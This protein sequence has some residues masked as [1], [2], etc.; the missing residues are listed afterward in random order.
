[1]KRWLILSLWLVVLLFAAHKIGAQQSLLGV[2]GAGHTTA[3]A[4]SASASGTPLSGAA[5]LTVNFTGAGANGTPPYTFGWTFGDGGTSAAQSPS[6]SYVTANTF[7]ATLTVTDSV[8]AT[9]QATVTITTS[10]T[11]AA[12]DL[13]ALIASS[14]TNASIQLACGTYRF[15]TDNTNNCGSNPGNYCQ[16]TPKL[17][18]KFIGQN[19][20]LSYPSGPL[21][22]VPTTK[23]CVKLNGAIVVPTNSTSDHSWHTFGSPTVWYNT[24]GSANVIN[25]VAIS[26]CADGSTACQYPQDLYLNDVMVPRLST[27]PVGGTGKCQW[28]M[29]FT[30]AVGA[31][32]ANTIYV[33]CDPTTSTAE[34]SV[35]EQ[36]FNL[37]AGSNTVENVTI[38]KFASPL[39]T[40]TVR[41]VSSGNLVNANWI[42][43]NHGEG[44][45]IDTGAAMPT[46][47]YNEI[48]ENG[49]VGI[50]GVT[51]AQELDSF[52]KIERNNE[53]GIA[54]TVESGGVYLSADARAS[55]VSNTIQN[56]NGHGLWVT[57]QSS[58]LLAQNNTISGNI[59]EG[60]RYEVSGSNAALASLSSVITNTIS[61]NGMN[62][63]AVCVASHVPTLLGGSDVC[64]GAGTGPSGTAC[65]QGAYLIGGEIE[66]IDGVALTVGG[67]KTTSGNTINSHCAGMRQTQDSR[68]AATNVYFANNTFNALSHSLLSPIGFSS[69]AAFNM[70]LNGNGFDFNTY[71]FLQDADWQG[72]STPFVAEGV[73]G[74]DQFINTTQ[75]ASWWGWRYRHNDISGSVTP[76][77]ACPTTV[78]NQK[79]FYVS[80][81]GSNANPG[82]SPSS[83]WATLAFTSTQFFNM[84][85]GTRVLL[86]SGNLWGEQFNIGQGVNQS[87]VGTFNNPIIISTYG[88]TARAKIDAQNTRSFCVNAESPNSHGQNVN[89]VI[90]DNIECTRA[91]SKG[92]T[93]ISDNVSQMHGIVFSNLLLYDNGPGCSN[94]NNA[95]CVGNDASGGYKNQLNF[96]NGNTGSAKNVEM[97]FDIVK[98]SGGHNCLEIHLDAGSALAYG[99]TIGPG[100]SHNF[101]DVKTPGDADINPPTFATYI[102]NVAT[103][104]KSTS[105]SFPGT[106]FYS[107]NATNGSPTGNV[108]WQNNL[109]YDSATSYGFTPSGCGGAACSAC[110]GCPCGTACPL[111]EYFY[112]NTGYAGSGAAQVF[113]VEEGVNRTLTNTQMTFINNIFDGATTSI[114]GSTDMAS[115]ACV[116]NHNNLGGVQHSTNALVNF[117]NI[118]TPST[119]DQRNVPPLYV[120]AAGLDFHLQAKSPDLNVG[121]FGQTL[122]NPNIGAFGTP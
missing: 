80:N 50:A 111:H 55:I 6:H 89:Y 63:P 1:M 108:I 44:V 23:P 116:E 24:V 98:W 54:Q 95:P 66:S 53:D 28:F 52:N 65:L 11:S 75:A 22:T 48:V 69:N 120:N 87:L 122:G 101:F 92:V 31:N 59:G 19:A 30:G 68:Q 109:A 71:N 67:V 37:T 62:N 83:P 42:T 9:A 84:P 115:N 81:F 113:A 25:A 110:T 16:L 114:Q 40:G 99:N 102:Y 79:C 91:T 121:V 17:G 97:L 112:N 36:A 26:T 70:F 107:E 72:T 14:A 56:N 2:V 94:V 29:D 39:N 43:H 27:L 64:A 12:T 38:E 93:F 57:N 86:N 5:P 47:S 20:N 106:A 88:G 58:A 82:T 96:V 117:C 60:V 61:N 105:I 41:H 51:T 49:Q 34:L 10:Q 3:P 118:S 76:N 45:R 103:T 35:V 13:T 100:C 7:T 90:L 77:P 74:S 15:A 33:S 18:Q 119:S 78:P 21:T 4:L 85:A 73:N 46:T 104:G 32:L 8:L